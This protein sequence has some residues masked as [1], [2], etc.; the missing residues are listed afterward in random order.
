[1]RKIFTF[2]SSKGHGDLIT[3]FRNLGCSGSRP[4]IDKEYKLGY[5][6]SKSK[7]SV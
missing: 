2:T 7:T 3:R 6:K 1:M 4:G 5:G